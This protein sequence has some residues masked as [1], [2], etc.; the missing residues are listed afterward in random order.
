MNRISRAVLA[1]AFAVA[2]MGFAPQALALDI[3]SD[4]FLGLIIP[5]TPAGDADEVTYVN[6]LLDLPLGGSTTVTIN[7]QVNGI[8]R[9]NNECSGSTCEDAVL[10]GLVKST[11]ENP[12]PDDINVTGFTYLLAKYDAEQ[13]GSLVWDITGLTSVDIP[14]NFGDCGNG[15]GC[16]LS[17]YTLMNPG[18]TPPPSVPEPGTL[19]LLG[20]AMLG[21]GF[22]TRKH[23]N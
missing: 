2:I 17:H 10:A 13:G 11:G 19:L 22:W 9:S 14:S 20:S 15:A 21:L 18:D 7:N 1:I 6:A 4:E 12:S 16:G 3:N 5:G 23:A 8:F